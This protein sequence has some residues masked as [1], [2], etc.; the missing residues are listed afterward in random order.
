M[1]MHEHNTRHSP[2]EIKKAEGSNERNTKQK[3]FQKESKKTRRKTVISSQIFTYT[4]QAKKI[5]S[6]SYSDIGKKK[7][8]K[9]RY[10][11]LLVNTQCTHT[12]KTNQ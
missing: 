1:H 12:N 11:L 4:T 9:K 10:R 8:D 3:I 6:N 7:A 5:M 2:P